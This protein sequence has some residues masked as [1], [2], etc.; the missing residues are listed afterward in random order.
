[1]TQVLSINQCKPNVF[2]IFEPKV[3]LRKINLF[4]CNATICKAN[5]EQVFKWQNLS[6]VLRFFASKLTS[7]P[8]YRLIVFKN[9]ELKLV[10][11]SDLYTCNLVSF[12]HTFVLEHLFLK[13]NVRTH[14]LTKR[15]TLQFKAF[16]LIFILRIGQ[17]VFGCYNILSNL[18]CSMLVRSQ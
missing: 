12:S 5:Y 18:I 1:M 8:M 2:H 16:I 3:E 7:F 11:L 15:F 9:S 6:K 10:K 4:L 13:L 14:S 17:L